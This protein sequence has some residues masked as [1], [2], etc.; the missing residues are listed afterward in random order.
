MYIASVL[1]LCIYVICITDVC[2]CSVTEMNNHAPVFVEIMSVTLKWTAVSGHVVATISASDADRGPNAGNFTFSLVRPE[3]SPPSGVSDGLSLFSITP[4]SGVV[5]LTDNL[6]NHVN[7]FSEILL[8]IKAQDQGSI[9]LSA[10]TVLSIIPIPVPLLAFNSRIQVPENTAENSN[11]TTVICREDGRQSNSLTLNLQGN[12]SRFFAVDIATSQL[13][14]V[15]KLDYESLTNRSDPFYRLELICQNQFGLSQKRQIQIEVVNVDDNPFLFGRNFYS[16][17][18]SESAPNGTSVINITATDD[19]FPNGNVN[20]VIVNIDRHFSIGQNNGE[21]LVVSQLDREQRDFYSFVVRAELSVSSVEVVVNITIADVNDEAPVFRQSYIINNLTSMNEIGD[22]VVTVAAEDPDLGENGQVTYTLQNN[23]FFA[24]NETTGVLSVDAVLQPNLDLSLVVYAT[25]NG[26]PELTSSTTIRIY[27]QP[28]PVGVRFT[29]MNYIFV[30]EENQPRGALIGRVEALVVDIRNVTLDN[31]VSYLIVNGS[32]TSPFAVNSLTGEIH[33]LSSLDY[34]LLAR[35]YVLIVQAF[36]RVS[37]QSKFTKE[38]IITIEV[39][40]VNDNPPQFSPAF[41][42]VVVNLYTPARSSIVNASA[43]DIDFMSVVAYSIEGD[44]SGLFQIDAQSGVISNTAVLDTARDYRF[45][46]TA[47]DGEHTSMA[48]VLISVDTSI[49]IVP[50][51]TRERYIFNLLESASRGSFV[52]MVEA[53]TRGNLSSLEFDH[54]RFRIITLDPDAFNGTSQA[55]D[56]LFHVDSESG[57][58][59]T[60]TDFEFDAENR[61]TYI[62]FVEVYSTINDTLHDTTV[63]AVELADTNDNPPV[64]AQSLYTRVIESN[65][66]AGSVILNVSASDRDS[67]TNSEITYSIEPLSFNFTVD[68]TSGE[69]FIGSNSLAIGDHRLTVVATD[70]GSPPLSGSATVVIAVIPATPSNLSFTMPVYHFSVPENAAANTLVGRVQAV[71]AGTSMSLDSITYFTSNL[72]ICLHVSPDNGEIRVSCSLDRET[73]PRYELHVDARD[74]DALGYGTVI[75]NVLDINDNPPRFSLDVYAEV[76]DDEF[77]NDTAILQVTAKDSDHRENGSITYTFTP[78]VG[79]TEDTL[80]YFRVD[81]SSGAVY[82]RESTIPIGDYRLTVQATDGGQPQAMSS[83]ALVLICVTRARPSILSFNTSTVLSVEENQPSSTLVGR[84]TLLTTG[85]EINPSEF[86]GNLHFSII[87]VDSTDTSTRTNTSLSLFGIQAETG[88]I[89]T[90]RPLDRETADRHVI[91]VL[92][93]FTQFGLSERASLNI[94]VTDQNDLQPQFEP[95]LYSTVIEENSDNNTV[96]I[97]VTIVDGDLGVNAE[98]DLSIS[99]LVTN[100]FGIRVR[101]IRHPYTYGEI[102]IQNTDLLVPGQY[103][104]E[105]IANDRGAISLRGTARVV[106]IVEHSPPDFISFSANPYVFQFTENTPRNIFVGSVS[107]EQP[108]TPALDG[109]VYSIVAG[110]GLGFFVVDGASGNITS[111]RNIDREV[112]LQLNLTVMAQVISQPLLAPTTSTVVVNI[113]DVNDNVPMF[114]SGSYSSTILE[115]DLSLGMSLIRVTVSDADAGPNAALTLSIVDISTHG[116]PSSFYITP[117]GDIF[118]NTT[119]LN[120]TTYLL[121]VTARDSG[122]PPF[123]SSTIVSVIVQLPVPSEI[124]FTQPEGYV[125]NVTENIASGPT[126]GVVELEYLPAHVVQFVTF[127]DNTTDFLVTHAVGDL[128]AGIQTI[129]V[130]D[131]ERVEIYRF[132]VE[133]RLTITTRS[134]AVD[135]RTSVDVTVHVIDVNDN[136]PVF[137]NFP[138]NLSYL[139]NRTR[140]VMVYHLQSTDLDSGANGERRYEILNVDIQDKFRIDS[141]TGEL[142]MSARVDREERSTYDITIQV[143]DSGTPSLSSQNTIRFT[144]LDI[145][146]NVPIMTNGFTISVRERNFS[147]HQVIAQLEGVDPDMGNN[148]TFEFD[149]V[150]T[151]IGGTTRPPTSQVVN[152]SPN[153]SVQLVRELDYEAEQTYTLH[154]RITDHGSPSLQFIYTNVTLT[155]VNEP[156]N[157]PRFS[158]GNYTSMISPRLLNGATLAQVTA[159]DVDTSDMIT[160]AIASITVQG[161]NGVE[162]AFR[163]DSR[164]GRIYHDGNRNVTPEANFTINVIAYDD[165]MFNLTST[166]VVNIIVLPE[167]LRFAQNTYTVEL[168]ENA[169]VGSEVTRVLL[170]QLSASSGVTFSIN[171]IQPSGQAGVF[172]V[173]GDQGQ[174]QAVVRL[175][176]RLDRETIDSYTIDVIARRNNELA[177]ARVSITVLDANDNTPVISDPPGTVITVVENIPSQQNITVVNATDRDIGSNGRL[178]YSISGSEATVFPFSINRNTGQITSAGDIDYETES[179]YSFLVRVSDSGTPSLAA[180]NNYVIEVANIN[181]EIPQLGAPSY[182]GELYAGAAVGERVL[183][184]QVRVTDADLGPQQFSLRVYFPPEIPSP[185]SDLYEFEVENEPPYFIRVVRQPDE[186]TVTESRLLELRV[187]VSDGGLRSN[188]PLFISIFTSSHLVRFRLGGVL[189]TDLLSCST[190]IENDVSSICALRRALGQETMMHVGSEVNFYNYSVQVSPE[191]VFE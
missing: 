188:V 123:S 119:N 97:N 8:T 56:N 153:G 124:R 13:S 99:G 157:V 66:M 165:S 161:N 163:I 122:N 38:A 172:N 21:I 22:L 175:A 60:L 166:T 174:S 61:T 46:V 30:V 41:Y 130:Y 67:T 113:V 25:D 131:Y 176:R 63:V 155:V 64:F 42:S 90:T 111:Q 182:F 43:I 11:L 108:I 75:V 59:S 86:V 127:T 154:V 91:S 52:G 55:G 101:D 34:D 115:S 16:A 3:F 37:N 93:N 142:F 39:S 156:D 105:V 168:L 71:D 85:G 58:I 162:P 177:T 57:S 29:R 96:V 125:F 151:Y 190:T 116:L 28:S 128:Q 133:A 148:G 171:V 70:G 94:M 50:T 158:R 138:R 152:I 141:G 98:V 6:L 104:F 135:L 173:R 109:L 149:E 73:E 106:I 180:I 48:I 47:S 4:T 186:A 102:Y 83:T 17:T 69:I 164:N 129:N 24:I 44:D 178:Q 89:Y 82:L 184:T 23:S 45:F 134:P 26:N 15:R 65:L 100:P 87:R 137:N 181:D 19:D 170:Q 36:H 110:S 18:V 187:E 74:G 139:E 144:L 189:V 114:T 80:I 77:G 120:A 62:F 150:A 107:I 159:T 12:F 14:L 53:V 118:T 51:F 78:T 35:Q 92:A 145:N 183:H 117:S 126:I 191:S 140:E 132:R 5:T 136:A 7:D 185:Y 160:Y 147:L 31:E 121:N 54:L 10:T 179:T 169:D 143:I 68:R 20:Y 84:A 167:E 79:E 49:S 81:E 32:V 40:D 146:D 76:I 72:S 112:H 1:K 2:L 88:D 27:V 9:P 103:V 33:L 95:M